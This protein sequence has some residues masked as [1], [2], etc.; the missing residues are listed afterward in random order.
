MIERLI[1][2]RAA[3]DAQGD[4]AVECAI[5]ELFEDG[6]LL[7]HVRRMRRVYLARRDAFAAALKRQLGEAIEFRLPAGGM[8]LWARVDDSIDL[9]GWIQAGE[10]EG[11]IFSDARAHDFFGRNTSHMR[12]GYSFHDEAELEEATRRMAR[13]LMRSR[14]P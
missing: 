12:L 2:F 13:S 8:A 5:A 6:E 11:V 14:K 10:R 9:P 1:S 7:R 3:S 4:A